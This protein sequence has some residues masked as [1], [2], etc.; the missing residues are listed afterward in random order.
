MGADAHQQLR[1][2]IQLKKKK[3]KQ[4]GYSSRFQG[5]SKKTIKASGNFHTQKH[6]SIVTTL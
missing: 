3:K 4:A 2:N 1:L 5:L 6:C